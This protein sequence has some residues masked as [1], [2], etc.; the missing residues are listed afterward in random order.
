MFDSQSSPRGLLS[1][2]LVMLGLLLL[3]AGGAM[4]NPGLVPY[5]SIAAHPTAQPEATALFQPAS[6]PSSDPPDPPAP[7]AFLP[8][9]EPDEDL[10]PVAPPPP[11]PTPV[12]EGYPPTRIV[13]PAIGL[14]APVVTTT[15][16]VVDV[17]G[18][19]QAVWQVPPMRAAGWHQGSAPLGVP[20]NT[21]LNGHNTTHGEV[22]RDLYRV[23]PGDRI[24]LYS[25]SRVFVYEVDEVLILPEAGQPLE[26]RLANAR[27]IQPTQDERVTLVTCHPYGSLRYRL[28]V[29]AKPIEVVPSE[30]K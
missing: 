19:Q 24:F 2:L 18:V 25:N 8:S 22:F 12:P 4:M 15:W 27:Y 30:A 29:I 6:L 21:V 1:T 23:Q 10:A 11:T 26:V 16:E 20:G 3:L 9:F 17:G 28:I 7:P 13:I 14:D 5:V